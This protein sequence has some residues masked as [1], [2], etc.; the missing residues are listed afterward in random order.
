MKI[1]KSISMVMLLLLLAVANV[2]AGESPKPTEEA[3]QSSLDH[4]TRGN[5]LDE[6]GDTAGAIKEYEIALSYDPKDTNTLFNMGMAY[7]KINKPDDAAKHFESVVSIDTKDTEAF[8]LLGLAYRGCG[9]IDD[10]VKTWEKS[11]VIDPDQ[12]L[13]KKFIKE[14]KEQ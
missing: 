11:L 8:N 6:K 2:S 13:P 7:L 9:R 3:L 12:T 10:A 1:L 5:M 14:A 4:Q